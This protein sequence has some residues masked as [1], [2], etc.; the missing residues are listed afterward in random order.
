MIHKF[1]L[2]HTLRLITLTHAQ[3]GQQGR[4]LSGFPPC[5]R[6]EQWS[7]PTASPS[8]PAR[9]SARRPARR[10]RLVGAGG[11]A[12]VAVAGSGARRRGPSSSPRSRGCEVWAARPRAGLRC[13]RLCSHLLPL[14]LT[15]YLGL[16]PNFGQRATLPVYGPKRVPREPGA[17]RVLREAQRKGRGRSFKTLP[18]SAPS[19]LSQTPKQTS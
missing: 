6:R 18:S 10:G 19:L 17:H 13:F 4:R 7:A 11:G 9:P 2:G 3:A 14:A 1:G 12:A 15:Q 8:G 5:L 16:L